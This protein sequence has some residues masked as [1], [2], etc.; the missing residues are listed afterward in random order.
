MF[1]ES[2][3][4]LLQHQEQ[5]RR[6]GLHHVADLVLELPVDAGLGELA[7]QRA[8]PGSHRHPEHRDEEQQAEQEPPEQAPARSLGHRVVAG[9]DVI[10]AVLVP[11]DH[12]DRVRL[13][14]QVGG[15]PPRLISGS[16]RGRLIRIPDGDQISHS[17]PLLLPRH[18]LPG[19]GKPGAPAATAK[20]PAETDPLALQF[21]LACILRRGLGAHVTLP[22]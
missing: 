4:D 10:T 5:R 16:E 18:C 21:L 14:D 11:R 13:D 1:R 6:A 2:R 20:R 17:V 19:A 8:Q 7:H 22:G 9:R 12:R 15:Q 3:G